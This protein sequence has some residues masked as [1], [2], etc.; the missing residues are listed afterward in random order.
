VNRFDRQNGFDFDD[1]VFDQEIQAIGAVNLDSLVNNRKH[2]L[3]EE[4]EAAQ[5]EFTRETLL[6]C[7]F[8]QAWAER[9]MDFNC[10][11]DDF[12]G[13]IVVHTPRVPRFIWRS[14]SCGISVSSVLS[15]PLW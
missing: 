14:T 13:D 9:T 6:V 11:S 12:A 8:E 5:S 3:P 1:N 2:N 10:G 7:R 15:V 4:G